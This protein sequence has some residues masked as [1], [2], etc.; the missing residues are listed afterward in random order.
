MAAKFSHPG[1]VSVYELGDDEGRPFIVQEYVEGQDLA[2]C[3]AE[4]PPS[5]REATRIILGVSEALAYAHRRNVIHRDLKPSNILLG[6]D[7]APQIADFGLAIREADRACELAGTPAY[8]A[9]EQVLFGTS[10]NRSD[11]WSVGV[12]LYRMLTGALPFPSDSREQAL[13][14]LADPGA[15][16]APPRK[17]CR[18]VPKELERICL[19]C[20]ARDVGARYQTASELADDLRRW[21]DRA[22]RARRLVTVAAVA[23]LTAIPLAVWGVL[24][25]RA[26]RDAQM[27]ERAKDGDLHTQR[28]WE[29]FDDG[30]TLR[31][32]FRFYD[33]AA[34]FED[35]EQEEKSRHRYLAAALS[36]KWLVRSF[37]HGPRLRGAACNTQGTAL[38][39]W[40]LDGQ[41]RYWE[42]DSQQPVFTYAHDDKILSAVFSP[43]GQ[44]AVTCS[45]D[46]TAKLFRTSGDHRVWPLPHALEV[47]GA[48]FHQ[49]RKEL[50]TWS[51]DGTVKWWSLESSPPSLIRQLDQCVAKQGA[52]ISRAEGALFI[53]QRIVTW[54]GA[55]VAKIWSPEGPQPTLVLKHADNIIG[56]APILHGDAKADLLT[57]SRDNTVKVWHLES[58]QA[59][60]TLRHDGFIHYATATV[61]GEQLLTCADDGDRGGVLRRWSLAT[62][63]RVVEFRDEENR[64]THLSTL[65]DGDLLVWGGNAVRY[66]PRGD[67]IPSFVAEHKAPLRAASYSARHARLLSWSKSEGS[68]ATQGKINVWQSPATEPIWKGDSENGG[69]LCKGRNAQWLTLDSD[70]VARL[71]RAPWRSFRQNEYEPWAYILPEKQIHGC[72]V[73]QEGDRVATHTRSAARMWDLETGKS[74]ELVHQEEL[75]GVLVDTRG[76]HALT[77]FLDGA[78]NVRLHRVN[79]DLTHEELLAYHHEGIIGAT[80]DESGRWAITWSM[81]E[82]ASGIATI[83]VTDVDRRQT[84]SIPIQT[85]LK[86]L[87]LNYGARFLSGGEQF[88]TWGGADVRLWKVGLDTPLATMPHASGVRS[89]RASADGSHII[90]CTEAGQ[91]RIWRLDS[92]T[93]QCEAVARISAPLVDSAILNGD[94][95]LAVFWGKNTAS[96]W[97]VKSD[98]P[99]CT[100]THTDRVRGGA[101]SPSGSRLATWSGDSV[102]HWVVASDSPPQVCDGETKAHQVFFTEDEQHLLTCSTNGTVKLW[103]VRERQPL[104]IFRHAKVDGAFWTSQNKLVTWNEVGC[105]LWDTDFDDTVPVDKRLLGLKSLS[106]SGE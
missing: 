43:D 58:D 20:L 42:T 30:D 17:L 76:R 22:A 19:K 40:D 56:A 54:G 45:R 82:M 67:E 49:T 8:M 85:G 88:L 84:T 105:R 55:S 16:P 50:L 11:I 2:A 106:A 53:G 3:L 101:F 1:I 7:N 100:F 25:H 68:S 65:E 6:T 28:A 74:V 86:E 52:G 102:Q 14:Q 18:N 83:N 70:G 94:G 39:T 46:S 80:L 93:S 75:A 13:A 12:I 61:D 10:D 91:V 29:A 33:A 9:P 32:A 71:W 51:R 72:V 27:A 73:S 78:D 48:T 66:L 79:R 41:V 15:N 36:A 21:R 99:V 98:R 104:Y 23:V 96:V 97:N 31:A 4:Q 47:Y 69:V 35:A 63:E 57:W 89:V 37:P 44:W 59:L 60:Q 90:V 5:P 103:S 87:T 24:Q 95:S 26:K 62:G 92:S 81:A 64:I 34:A 77:W 38:L